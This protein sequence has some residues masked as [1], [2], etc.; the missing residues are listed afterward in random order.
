GPV[1]A[2]HVVETPE[3]IDLLVRLG[4][5]SPVRTLAQITA[6]LDARLAGVDP[7]DPEAVWSAIAEVKNGHVLRVGLADF[8]GALDSLAVCAELTK[9]AEACLDRAL[10]IVTAQL[11]TR[12]PQPANAN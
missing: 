8:A 10:A 7:A 11:V 4:Q 12:Y 6:D 3:P 9:I 1:P 5:P 2:R